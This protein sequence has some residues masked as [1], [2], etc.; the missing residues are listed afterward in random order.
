MSE[1]FI[2]EIRAFAFDKV[3]T[4]WALCNGQLL[5]IANNQALFSLLGTTYGGNGTSTFALPNLQGRVPVH[6][7]ADRTLGQSAG[8]ETHT[9]TVAEMPV[10][11]HLAM[12]QSAAATESSPEGH[13]WSVGDNA[14]GYASTAD[15]SMSAAAIGSSGGS[16]AHNNMQPFLV[17][18]FCI[19]TQ[20]LFPSRG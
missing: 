17:V 19:A 7:S 5:N 11:D 14:D 9:L 4:G 10:H 2:G 6:A 12:A 3:P 13:Y 20:G 8:E 16:Q 1:P 15:A 18:S